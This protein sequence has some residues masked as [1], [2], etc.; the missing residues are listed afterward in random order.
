[1]KNKMASQLYIRYL[2]LWMN[3]IQNDLFQVSLT[4]A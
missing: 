1:M 3:W 4:T 2:E